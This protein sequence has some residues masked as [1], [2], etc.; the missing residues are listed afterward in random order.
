MLSHH[1]YKMQF[2]VTVGK[3]VRLG[4]RHLAADVNGITWQ[5]GTPQPTLE[6]LGTPDRLMCLHQ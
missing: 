1:W 6:W 4:T 5:P 3:N 2:K